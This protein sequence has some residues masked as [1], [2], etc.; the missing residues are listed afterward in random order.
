MRGRDDI[1]KTDRFVLILHARMKH[2]AY[3]GLILI[4]LAVMMYDGLQLRIVNVVSIG[5]NVSDGL[6]MQVVET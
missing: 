3:H 1:L 5:F 6:N 4:G 2:Q